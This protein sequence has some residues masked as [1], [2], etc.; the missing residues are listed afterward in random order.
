MCTKFDD[1][2]FSHSSDMIGALKFEWV[3]WPDHTPI[4]NGVLSVGCDLHI[5][6]YIKF[7]VFANNNYKDA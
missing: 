6:P 4:R 1:F 7:E 3:T 2:R 5:K